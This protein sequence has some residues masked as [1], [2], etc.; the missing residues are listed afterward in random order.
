MLPLSL[1]WW[2]AGGALAGWAG[3]RLIGFTWPIG[4]TAATVATPVVG[5]LGGLLGG[6]L[7]RL[8][9]A[10][11]HYFGVLNSILAAVFGTVLLLWFVR[12]TTGLG[13][14]R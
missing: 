7:L 4:R 2:V 8:F 9:G 3:A 12:T 11:V 13:R 6:G 14:P 5:V 10:Q 1:A